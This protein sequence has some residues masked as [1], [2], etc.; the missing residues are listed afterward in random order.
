M[1]A[2]LMITMIE[3]AVS[4]VIVV[5]RGHVSPWFAITYTVAIPFY[6]GSWAVTA[7]RLIGG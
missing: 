7:I 4:L 2:L 6:V 5:K 1:T 3:A